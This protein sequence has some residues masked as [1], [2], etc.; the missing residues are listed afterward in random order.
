MR[1]RGALLVL[2][3]AVVPGRALAQDAGG[4][5]S[6]QDGAIRVVAASSP[7]PGSLRVVSGVEWLNEHGYITAGHF[8]ER[9]QS[10]TSIAWGATRWL[11]ISAEVLATSNYDGAT[12][13]L[14]I[15]AVG[16]A[17]ASARVGGALF[18]LGRARVSAGVRGGARVLQG[19]KQGPKRSILNPYGYGLLSVEGE[20]WRVSANAGYYAD[21]SKELLDPAFKATPG[22]TYAYGIDEYNALVGGVAL[23]FPGARVAPLLEATFRDD[24]GGAPGKPAAV[25]TGGLRWSPGSGRVTMTA[26]CDVGLSGT[27]VVPGRLRAPN[28]NLV[29]GLTFRVGTLRHASATAGAPTEVPTVVPQPGLPPNMG[30][31]RGHVTV[32]ENG[33]P[34]AGAVVILGNGTTATTDANGKFEF[35]PMPRGPVKLAIRHDEYQGAGKTA[36]VSVG[37]ATSLAFSLSRIPPPPEGRARLL[38]VV[39]DESGKPIA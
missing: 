14:F 34:L 10:S 32:E 2:I 4:G 11:E 22:Q 30:V 1:G 3:A 21:H 17:D 7:E 38:G 39:T 25:G 12:D 18:S 33:A 5:A 35:P 26:A 31:L 23:D 37:Q 9:T 29:G 27:E 20:V 15:T 8:H 24:L 6:G 19:D 36:F 13:P 16:D 28:W